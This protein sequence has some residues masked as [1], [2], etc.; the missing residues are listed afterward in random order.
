MEDYGFIILG[1]I[2][3][4]TWVYAL[5]QHNYA[6]L[7]GA[8][9]AAAIHGAALY[10]GDWFGPKAPP[11]PPEPP[12]T[13]P[14]EMPNP[15]PP[16]EP[17]A[18]PIPQDTDVEDVKLDIPPPTGPE[19]LRPVGDPTFRMKPTVPPPPGLAPNGPMHR[20][21]IDRRVRSSGEP[22]IDAK[23]LKHRPEPSL[24]VEP[25]YPYEL[26]QDNVEGE[27]VLVFL[28]DRQGQPRDIYVLSSTHPGFEQAAIQA[29]Q[30]WRF[31]PGKKDGKVVNTGNVHQLIR[32]SLNRS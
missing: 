7:T 22:V 5:V 4:G 27:V 2:A 9:A 32:F 3:V 13:I 26:K 23:L 14:I 19:N 20:I 17:P 18:E 15:E 10:P 8:I 31:R 25:I 28:V 30:K 24:Q 1:V 21:P 12:P 6:L 11:P 16:D 29:L